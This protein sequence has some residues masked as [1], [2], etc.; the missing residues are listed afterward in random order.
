MDVIKIRK[1]FVSALVSHYIERAIQDRTDTGIRLGVQNI[2]AFHE[3]GD[4]INFTLTIDGEV[5]E[6]D[7]KKL[8][9][10]FGL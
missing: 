4:T 2:E 3:E 1:G 9:D 7:A 6:A 8:L 5:S 10:T